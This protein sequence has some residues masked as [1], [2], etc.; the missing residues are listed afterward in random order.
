LNRVGA[1]HPF[2]DDGT[3]PIAVW[4]QHDCETIRRAAQTVQGPDVRILHLED[5]RVH[6][7]YRDRSA[8]FRSMPNPF[9]PESD[10]ADEC[11]RQSAPVA[12]DAAIVPPE[13]KAGVE[14]AVESMLLDGTG[15][16]GDGHVCVERRDVDRERG[17]GPVLDRSTA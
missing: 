12:A 14:S 7:R 4:P 6:Q 13:H 16:S 17:G 10:E 2:L 9:N 11:D 1:R 5:D 8:T 3:S 15:N